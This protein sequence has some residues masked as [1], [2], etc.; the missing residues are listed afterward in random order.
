MASNTACLSSD[1][2]NLCYTNYDFG[3][4]YP[5]ALHFSRP[6]APVLWLPSLDRGGLQTAQQP[7]QWD[8]ALTWI[9]YIQTK[10]LPNVDLSLEGEVWYQGQHHCTA[11]DW[12]ETM[13]ITIQAYTRRIALY[14]H[15]T[16]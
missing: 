11:L 16:V 4:R 1:W 7:S 9:Q 3:Q 15:S 2:H 14:V 13:Q 10:V 6:G 12:L 5:S 8:L